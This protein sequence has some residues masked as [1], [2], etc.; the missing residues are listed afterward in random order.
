MN[1]L[2][3]GNIDFFSEI[4]DLSE[5]EDN[6]DN[7]NNICLINKSALTENYITLHCKHKFNY[8]P[9]Y[10]EIF[11]QK[12]KNNSRNNTKRLAPYQI[13]CPYCR[14][15]QNRLI[16]YIPIY[17]NVQKI[18]GVNT[19]DSV[20]MVH[21]LCNHKFISGKNKDTYCN[22]KGFESKYGDICSTHYKQLE[23]KA[24]KQNLKENNNNLEWTDEMELFSKKHTINQ[25]KEKLKE[26]KLKLSGVKRELIL[27]L[28]YKN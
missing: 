9:L 1:Y 2:I 4:N 25:I 27:R 21:K 28:F 17:D 6:S 5:N 26:N 11:S 15:I 13:I 14:T 8:L 22:K 23:N 20:V 18:F 19:P 10:K 3:E 24:I 16:P 12:H 7:N